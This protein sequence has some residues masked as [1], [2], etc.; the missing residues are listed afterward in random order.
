[1]GR[2]FQG[3]CTLLAR[4]EVLGNSKY[5]LGRFLSGK[6]EVEPVIGPKTA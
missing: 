2:D 3:G 6:E 1:M 5:L 4:T